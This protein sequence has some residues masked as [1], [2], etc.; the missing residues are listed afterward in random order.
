MTLAES[1]PRN[2]VFDVGRVLIDFGYDQ[3]FALL[4]SRGADITNEADFADRVGLIPYEHGRIS[5]DEFLDR[6]ASQ[7]KKP[8]SKDAIARAWNDI[9]SPVDEMFTLA[10]QLKSHCH[11]YLLSNTSR[12]HWQHLQRC[13]PL[14]EL[15][16]DL[17]ASYEVGVM[18]PMAGIYRACEK[19][20][21]IRPESTIFID[22]KVENVRGALACGWCGHHHTDAVTTEAAIRRF[23]N[24]RG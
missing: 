13:Y 15:S 21:G 18:K 7:L 5:D 14:G 16:H 3:L 8:L 9:F 12:L 11:V 1:N 2:V 24:D 6:I 23:L 22:D 20:F 19:R 10:R 4:R 17:L